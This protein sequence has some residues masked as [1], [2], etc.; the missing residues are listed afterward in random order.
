[1]DAE[2][3]TDKLRARG[4]SASARLKEMYDV[5]GSVGGPIISD[6]L[7]FFTAHR[8]WAA[9]RY[10]PGNYWNLT[11]HTLFYTPD[12][13]RQAYTD[14]H[15]WDSSFR[16]N[17]QVAQKHKIN[18]SY[19]IQNDC[20]CFWG[21]DGNFAPEAVHE[22]RYNPAYLPQV[23]W[24][25]PAS[26]RL[27]FESGATLMKVNF[28]SNPVHY[29][30]KEVVT[31]NDISIVELSTGFRYGSRGN[32][33]NCCG[34]Y[35][36]NG[37]SNVNGRASMSYVTG[38]HA[39]KVGFFWQYGFKD[40]IHQINQAVSYSFLNQKPSSITLWASPLTESER[41]IDVGTYVQDQWTVR[42][43]TLNLGVRFDYLNAWVPAQDL[44]GGR[45]VPERHF[46]AVHDVPNWKDVS[47]RFG[48]AYDLRGD[49]RT[50][51]KASLGRYVSG[52][53]MSIAT[54]NN[55]VNTSVNS[56]TRT[57]AD[58]NGDFIPQEQELGRLSDASFGQLKILTRY[59]DDVL[60]GF[61]KRGY[62]W[63]SS[64]SVQQQLWPGTAVTVGYFRTWWGNFTSVDNLA[65]APEDYSPF[66][67][68]APVDARLPGGGGDQI[69]GLYDVSPTKFGQINNLIRP[70]SDFGNQ[71][72]V[73]NGVDVN[74]NI[75]FADGALLSG[76]LATGKTVTD[77]CVVVDSP[78]L[79]FCRVSPPL[80]AGTQV[81]LFGVYPLPWN[82]QTSVTF[83]DLPGIPETATFV[84]T[85]ALVAPSLG[86]NLASGAAGTVTTELIAPNSMFEDR[87]RQLDIRLTRVFKIGGARAQG[88]FDVYN[89]LNAS[90]VLAVN[91]RYGPSWLRVQDIMAGR[92]FKIGAQLDF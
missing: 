61:G 60:H 73:F 40:Q 74:L 55:P 63:Q 8:G 80:S 27:L 41:M 88:M 20:Q 90:P 77:N 44:S 39:L 82:L 48:V 33:L 79:R 24:S 5:N 59:S 3:L 51:V 29:D 87:I 4:I 17:W 69:C 12:L 91:T 14:S 26:S 81:K 83:Q 84:A 50:A 2:N 70:T 42:R 92:L 64:A 71:S 75:R 45:W 49:G 10:I 23:T 15:Y 76:G 6:K 67:I 65:V 46:D 19:S 21:L 18:L 9:G 7:W 66:C 62:N 36:N 47:P 13:S 58:A 43:L 68:T 32:G 38:S 28:G 37:S 30:G 56:A 53:T 86:R 25:Y 85:N 16:L 1:M 35:S 57:W 54:A 72:M 11:Q 31:P 22:S 78:Q 52:E 34:S 89:V